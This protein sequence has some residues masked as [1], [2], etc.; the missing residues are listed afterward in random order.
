M[1]PRTR[2]KNRRRDIPFPDGLLLFL[3]YFGIRLLIL[4]L[5]L[6]FGGGLLAV[7]FLGWLVG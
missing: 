5:L 4:I 1:E 6:V 7:G 3:E 2:P